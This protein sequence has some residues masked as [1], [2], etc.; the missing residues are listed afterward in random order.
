MKDHCKEI[1]QTKGM[2]RVTVDELIEETTPQARGEYTYL[3]REAFGQRVQK[4]GM[5]GNLF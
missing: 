3:S 4:G 5:G 2:E 1:L